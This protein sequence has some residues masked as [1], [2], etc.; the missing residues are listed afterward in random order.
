MGAGKGKVYIVGAGPGDPGLLT[1][2]AAQLLREAHVVVHD[3][4]VSRGVLDMIPGGCEVIDVGKGPKGSAGRQEEINRLLVERALR[5]QRVV[6]LKG[7][8]PYVFGRGGEEA[9]ALAEAGVEFEVVPGVTSAVAAAAAA[10]IPVTQR[11][12]SSVLVITTGHEGEGKEGSG[13]DWK[14]LGALEATLVILMGAGRM[15]ENLDLLMGGGLDPSTPA[16][17]IERATLPD[18]R[19]VTGTAADIAGR[20]REAGMASPVVLVVGKVV[21]LASEL[22]GSR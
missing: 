21:S 18:Q 17:V 4:L 3:R 13:V 9:R 19:I 12:L 20:A 14:A 1:L 22:G 10:G 6:R 8:D 11:D 16:A 15:E 7:G 2:R 5:G